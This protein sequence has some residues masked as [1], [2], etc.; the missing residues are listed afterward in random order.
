MKHLLSDRKKL[1]FL[2][3]GKFIYFFLDFDGTLAPIVQTPDKAVLPPGTKKVLKQLADTPLCKIAIISGRSVRDVKARVG[4]RKA[5]YVGNHGFEIRGPKINFSSPVSMQYRKTLE[6][7][8]DRL[9]KGLKSFKGVIIEDKG[10]SLSVHYRLSSKKDIPKIKT[11]FYSAVFLPKLKDEIEIKPGKMVLEIRPPVLWNKGM[12]VLWLLARRIFLAN[13][14]EKILPIYI[15][16]DKTDEDAFGSL[17][18]R[19]IT[20]FVGKPH[21]TKAKFYLRNTKEVARLLN[22][23]LD[24]LKS[25]D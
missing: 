10:F 6:G 11:D 12:V 7:I 15:G 17:R 21:D 14:K 20:V 8:K 13:S 23:I 2:L 3:K 16:D 4:L 1:K 24:E 18:N 25:E 22:I 9:D 19:G 5:L